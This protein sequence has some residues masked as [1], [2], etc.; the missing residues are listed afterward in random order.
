M[1]LLIP[2]P[3]PLIEH[4]C[5]FTRVAHKLSFKE[6]HVEAGGIV[7]N[8]LEEEHLDGQF[9]FILEM[10][11]WDFCKEQAQDILI[12]RTFIMMPIRFPKENNKFYNS[13][14]SVIHMATRSYRKLSIM[15]IT[16]LMQEAVTDV[17][18]CGV[19]SEP[20]TSSLLVGLSFIMLARAANTASRYAITPII[21]AMISEI[22]MYKNHVKAE[23][24]HVTTNILQYCLFSYKAD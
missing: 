10:C 15:I 3:A 12:R 5:V 16:K 23:N 2:Q 7:V 9:V 14:M 4:I 22:L 17:A 24:R 13:P 1:Y 20:T 8:K 11:F 21:L 19:I 18:S 6:G